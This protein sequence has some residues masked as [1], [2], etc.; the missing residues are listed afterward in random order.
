MSGVQTWK[1][2]THNSLTGAKFCTLP[3]IRVIVIK[4]ETSQRTWKHCMGG[5][6]L[7]GPLSLCVVAFSTCEEPHT[8][9]M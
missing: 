7:G 3:L 9:G 4:M 2:V 6:I 1:V 8:A 5:I